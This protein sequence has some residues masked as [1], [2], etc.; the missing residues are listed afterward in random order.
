MLSK[1]HP[2]PAVPAIIS[3]DVTASSHSFFSVKKGSYC[4]KHALACSQWLMQLISCQLLYLS[5]WASLLGTCSRMQSMAVV[6]S[7]LC[8]RSLTVTA[9]AAV[10]VMMPCR[11]S[12]CPMP[13]AAAW[14]PLTAAVFDLL[15]PASP[16]W[17][18]CRYAPLPGEA[19]A[20]RASAEPKKA[21]WMPHVLH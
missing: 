10:T 20:Y 15:L 21:F 4:L 7:I 8:C 5:K 9:V 17:T 12:P 19:P 18:L 3:I 2:L 14:T 13:P 1:S 6:T 16:P 11:P